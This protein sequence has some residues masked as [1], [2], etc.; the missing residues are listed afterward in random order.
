M[1]NDP[2]FLFRSKRILH[3]TF[4]SLLLSF[5]CSDLPA[6][7]TYT[8]SRVIEGD[9]VDLSNGEQVHLIG[10]DCPKFENHER[11]RRNSERLGVDPEHYESFAQK[12]RDFTKRLIE[13]QKLRLEYDESNA[14]IGHR[15]KTGRTLAYIVVRQDPK[16]PF[17]YEGETYMGKKRYD[18]FF[19]DGS[20]VLVPW[21]RG[22]DYEEKF[23]FSLNGML[24]RSGHCLVNNQFP[25]KHVDGFQELEEDAKKN[26]RG[27]WG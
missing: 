12:A 6:E 10:V 20:G 26:K 17:I 23:G 9:S 15:D 7:E 14:E 3:L 27:L 19:G 22:E 16:A 2:T 5:L 1:K 24:I 4:S 11:N 21:G 13:H 18:D 25:F 8:V